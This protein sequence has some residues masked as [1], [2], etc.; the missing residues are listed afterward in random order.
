[1]GAADNNG[2]FQSLST[3]DAYNG[4]MDAAMSKAVTMRQAAIPMAMDTTTTTATV[5]SSMPAIARATPTVMTTVALN[6]KRTGR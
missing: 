1:M 3:D 4:G 6:V 2:S 5:I